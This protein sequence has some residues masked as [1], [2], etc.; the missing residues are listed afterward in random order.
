MPPISA[1]GMG[2]DFLRQCYASKMRFYIGYQEIQLEGRWYFCKQNAKVLPLAHA[3]TSSTYDG[4]DGVNWDGPPIGEIK[5]E[6]FV[7]LKPRSIERLP[8]FGYCGTAEQWLHGIDIADAGTR[9]NDADAILKCCKANP[10]IGPSGQADAGGAYMSAWIAQPGQADAGGA[11][12]R[13]G[14]ILVAEGGQADAGGAVMGGGPQLVAEGGQADAGG[15]VMGG[16]PQL[17]AEG[18]QADA[19]GAVMGNG[20]VIT[21]CSSV[22]LP[23]DLFLELTDCAGIPSG[24][25]AITYDASGPDG[26]GWYS[27]DFTCSGSN[28]YFVFDCDPLTTWRVREFTGIYGTGS[29]NLSGTVSPVN[30]SGVLAL[31]GPCCSPSPTA[32]V[33]Q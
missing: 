33:T 31:S 15:A 30:L 12:L 21:D 6:K 8:G 27:D 32:T 10:Q 20:G 16:G 5:P 3:F 2:M 23:F 17:V 13:R 4:K 9:E 19:G 22:E 18:G 7:G 28:V 29:G 26:P 24:P 1:C 11:D 25:F 14:R